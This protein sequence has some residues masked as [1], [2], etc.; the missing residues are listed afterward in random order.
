M[1]VL[2]LH[3]TE[4]VINKIHEY[5]PGLELVEKNEDI[6]V[7][8]KDYKE[9]IDLIRAIRKHCPKYLQEYAEDLS[10]VMNETRDQG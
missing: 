9:S 5:F 3:S 4:E 6:I 7:D 10:E 2:L 1:R 8:T